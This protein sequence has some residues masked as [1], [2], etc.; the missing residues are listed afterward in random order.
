MKEYQGQQ[1]RIL[2]KHEKISKF[3]IYAIHSAENTAD[4][5]HSS[6]TISRGWRYNKLSFIR[7]Y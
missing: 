3:S 4:V 7:T 1:G 2:R 5:I 6:L